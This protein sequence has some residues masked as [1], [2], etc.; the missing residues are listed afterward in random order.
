[1][2]YQTNCTTGSGIKMWCSYFQSELLITG[3]AGIQPREP[4]RE[5]Q[6]AALSVAA[7][8][9]STQAV[10]RA[11]LR[12]ACRRA[13]DRRA[14]H[15]AFMH[16]LAQ[17]STRPHTNSPTRSPSFSFSHAQRHRKQSS[18]LKVHSQNFY[19]LGEYTICDRHF[20]VS[21]SWLL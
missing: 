18:L 3:P 15:H 13:D 12:T 19:M 21:K 16:T 11:R 2:Q 20:C 17:T 8:V 5:Q 7:A 1:M 10:A 14:H 6:C 4:H 9:C